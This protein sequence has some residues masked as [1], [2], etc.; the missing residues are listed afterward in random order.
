[1]RDAPDARERGAVVGVGGE[2]L[3]DEVFCEGREGHAEGVAVVVEEGAGV[4]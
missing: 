1:M 4:L 3:A 2:H